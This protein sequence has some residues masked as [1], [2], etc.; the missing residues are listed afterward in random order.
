M[1]YLKYSVVSFI[2]ILLAV[3]IGLN[4]YRDSIARGVANRALRG[5]DFR[6][7]DLTVDSIRS[8]MVKFGDLV[9]ERED[10]MRIEVEG[11]TLPLNLRGPVQGALSVD[12]LNIL[13]GDESGDPTPLA[14]LIKAFLDAPATI[15]LN[16]VNVARVSVPGLPELTDLAW[17]AGDNDQYLSFK[18]DRYAVSIAIQQTTD[19]L[20]HVSQVIH[21][22]AVSY[23]VSVFDRRSVADP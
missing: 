5:Q 20:N 9:L 12:G 4:I 21:G 19:D 16:D 18:A 10:G 13:S 22:L 7:T 8:E 1:K 15:P 14:A 2:L 17:R 11:I 3:V 23:P 6:V